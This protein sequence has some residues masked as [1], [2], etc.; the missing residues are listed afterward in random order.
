MSSR[1]LSDSLK[2]LSPAKRDRLESIMSGNSGQVW[3]IET[4][5]S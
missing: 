4:A 2:E 1:D 3:F 5:T